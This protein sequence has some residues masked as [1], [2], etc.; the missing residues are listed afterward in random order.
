MTSKIVPRNCP[1]VASAELGHPPLDLASPSLLR[2]WISLIIQAFEK[3]ASQLGALVRAE[4][5]S[6]SVQLFH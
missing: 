3:T 6:L 1:N 4:L 2:I 5:G